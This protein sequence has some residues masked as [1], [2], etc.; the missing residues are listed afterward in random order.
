MERIAFDLDIEMPVSGVY[1]MITSLGGLRSWLS[2]DISGSPAKGETLILG[3]G[4]EQSTHV[5]VTDCKPNKLLKWTV[6]RS[7]FTPN[8]EEFPTSV[9]IDLT[10]NASRG[11]TLRMRHDGWN[12]ITEFYRISGFQW[13]KALA[14]LKLVCETGKGEPL[15]HAMLTSR[16]ATGWF[17]VS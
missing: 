10:E 3:F 12:E 8:Q 5:L 7:T 1:E 15:T 14:S 4:S 6:L 9:R 2:R 17:P 13:E 11:T 16:K